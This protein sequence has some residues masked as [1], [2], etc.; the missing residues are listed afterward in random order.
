MSRIQQHHVLEILT[1]FEKSSKEGKY[2]PL[3]TKYERAMP[4]KNNP[5]HGILD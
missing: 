4:M 3:K 1:G 2:L 5:M